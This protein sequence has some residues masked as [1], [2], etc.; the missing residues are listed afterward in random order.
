MS[1]LDEQYTVEELEAA[2]R[3]CEENIEIFTQQVKTQEKQM[4][5]FKLMLMKVKQG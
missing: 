4:L 3:R 5:E 1:S 2:I